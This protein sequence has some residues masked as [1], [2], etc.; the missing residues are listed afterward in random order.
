MDE[1]ENSNGNNE[2][3]KR[4]LSQ[5]AYQVIQT[6]AHIFFLFS[7]FTS[8]NQFGDEKEFWVVTL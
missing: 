8:I 1:A 5:T 7:P 3:Y 4:Y 6:V 2:Q